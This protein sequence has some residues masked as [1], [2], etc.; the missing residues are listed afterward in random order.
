MDLTTTQTMEHF[1][2]ELQGAMNKAAT[3][4]LHRST[5]DFPALDAIVDKHY[6]VAQTF[7]DDAYAELT[8]ADTQL[9]PAQRASE[10]ALHRMLIQPYVLSSEAMRWAVSK[11]F[12]YPGDYRMV[13]YLF[14]C[15]PR[16]VSPLGVL[17]DRWALECGP[18]QS[19][20]AR[21]AW[22]CSHVARRASRAAGRPLQVLSFA[23]G[24]E[25]VLRG[26]GEGRFDL[27]LCDFDERALQCAEEQLTRALQRSGG[28]APT[29]RTCKLSAFALIRSPDAA[30][31]LL[32]PAVEVND[33]FD[34]ILVLGLLDY[35]K[36][37]A[38]ERFLRAIGG[39]LA[40]GG[41]ILLTNLHMENP[42]RAFMEYA[43]EWTVEHRTLA[44][45]SELVA[46]AGRFEA[47]EAG[48][49]PAA[50]TNLFYAG[51]RT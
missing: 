6:P 16:G 3:A 34:V 8:R 19:H 17:L 27:T 50:G 28:D 1:L 13:D 45:F 44:G 40:P 15:R 47:L 23:C 48:P 35:L 12:G 20:R 22:A 43:L 51:R 9:S 36:D 29:I 11:P 14:E 10:R 39:V 46:R 5:A 7:L 37:E 33:G 4:S 38:V 2:S 18:S 26:L 41:D 30:R 42:W 31:A 24:S 25:Q 32:S 21:R 49:D